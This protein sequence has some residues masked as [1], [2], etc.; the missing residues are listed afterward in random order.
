MAVV[1]TTVF[2]IGCARRIALL[3]VT[4]LA[5]T[6]V[7]VPVVRTT[8]GGQFIVVWATVVGMRMV[9]AATYQQMVE[10]HGQS[11]VVHQCVH[12]ITKS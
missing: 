1:A 2:A 7:A 5:V 12:E 10:H 11:Q 3:P 8:R 9:T 6:G 4:G